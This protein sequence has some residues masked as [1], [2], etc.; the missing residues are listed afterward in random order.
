MNISAINYAIQ[1]LCKEVVELPT[2]DPLW[3]YISEDMLLTE[4][5][6]CIFSSQIVFEVAVA[7]VER[8]QAKGLLRQDYIAEDGASPQYVELVR[9]ALDDPLRVDF[10]HNVKKNVTLRFRNRLSYL[11]ASTLYRIYGSGGSIRGLLESADSPQHARTL[12]I[13]RVCGFG[14]KQASLYLRRIGY[15]SELAVLDTHVVDY[16]RLANGIEISSSRLSQLPVY[17]KIEN[18]FKK[19]AGHFGHSVGC[20]DLAMWITMRV[21][22]REYAT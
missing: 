1:E 9:Y 6:V 3:P 4:L 7:A 16:L 22:K 19:I 17:E 5:A 21:A 8:L 13:E 10:G 11:L 20:V 15:C 12:L 14:P 18:E 2:L